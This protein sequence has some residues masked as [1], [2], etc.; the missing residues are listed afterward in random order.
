M[1]GESHPTHDEIFHGYT[2]Y[3]SHG[4]DQFGQLGHARKKDDCGNEIV[5]V[6][7]NLSFDIIITQVTCGA[8]H[9]LILSQKKELFSIGSNKFGQLGLN[10]RH[11]DFSTTPLLIQNSAQ[12][13]IKK[14]ASGGY[15]NLI[16]TENGDIQAWG[17]ND[18]GQCG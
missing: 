3:F 13:S 8:E 5:K 9:T 2:E 10:D 7:K 12:M 14:I 1:G 4:S 15:H 17:S 18:Q 16:L 6:P 11:L